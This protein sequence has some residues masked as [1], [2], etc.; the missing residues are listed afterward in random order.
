MVMLLELSYV[1]WFLEIEKSRD[2]EVYER[3]AVATLWPR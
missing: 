1:L 2:V 3:W